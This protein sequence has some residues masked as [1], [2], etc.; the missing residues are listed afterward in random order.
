[1]NFF[2]AFTTQDVQLFYSIFQEYF[3]TNSA[4]IF[5][6]KIQLGLDVFLKILEVEGRSALEL[7][8]L[9]RSCQNK[10]FPASPSPLHT[11]PLSRAGSPARIFDK[12]RSPFL[13]AKTL[14]RPTQQGN[15][16]TAVRPGATKPAPPVWKTMAGQQLRCRQQPLSLQGT[17]YKHKAGTDVSMYTKSYTTSTHPYF[18]EIFDIYLFIL[19]YFL[20]TNISIGKVS[21]WWSNLLFLLFSI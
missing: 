21:L 5:V 11:N 8:R 10:S 4:L 17:D 9:E 6:K 16:S 2:S 18:C 3:A 12:E 19:C 1:M 20:Y 13:E 7:D 15:R 14:L